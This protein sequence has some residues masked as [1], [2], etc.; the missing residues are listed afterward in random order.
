MSRFG[1]TIVVVGGAGVVQSVTGWDVDN[2][3][4]LNPIILPATWFDVLTNGHDADGTDLNGL[5]NLNGKVG[6]DVTIKAD[7]GEDLSLQSD[8]GASYLTIDGFGN[9]YTLLNQISFVALSGFELYADAGF[10]QRTISIDN[11][12]F[13]TRIGDIDSAMN[14]TFIFID[15]GNQ[16]LDLTG[17]AY[18]I[19]G[20]PGDSGTF[21]TADAKTVTVVGGIITSIV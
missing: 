20:V 7:I 17:L 9:L 3:D 13:L 6:Q 10:S 4:P 12:T 16:V 18:S 19:N 14:G 21:T 1:S 11:T 8:N 15:D 2:T 5:K